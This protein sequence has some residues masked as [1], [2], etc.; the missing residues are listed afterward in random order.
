MVTPVL[1]VS[2]MT[3]LVA[4]EIELGLKE[5]EPA[6]HVTVTGILAAY[7]AGA[8]ATPAA[9]S[10]NATTA[11]MMAVFLTLWFMLVL[12]EAAPA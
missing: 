5:K 6:T 9:V 1:F 12:Q 10:P 8:A 4:T 7:A 3:S 2:C 11:G